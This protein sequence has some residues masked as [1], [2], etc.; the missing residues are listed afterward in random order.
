MVIDVSM[1][2]MANTRFI[3]LVLIFFLSG[4]LDLFAQ[5]TNGTLAVANESGTTIPEINRKIA[6]AKADT[7]KVKLLIKQSHLYWHAKTNKNNFLDSSRIAAGLAQNLSA[8]LHFTQ[9]SNEANFMLCRI[10]VEKGDVNT[11]L[12]IASKVYGEERVRLLLTVGEHFVIVRELHEQSDKAYSVIKEAIKT[13]QVIGSR[14]WYYESLLL[15][16]K[17]YFVKGDVSEGKK[18]ILKIISSCDRVADYAGGAR[19]WSELGLYMPKSAGTYKDV[20]HS[21]AM[22]VKFYLKAGNRREA[23]YSLRDKSMAHLVANEP[24][25]AEQNG[26]EVLL[27][28]KTLNEQPTFQ[29]LRYMSNIYQVK[30]NYPKA[31]NFALAAL[32]R[33]GELSDQR[34]FEAHILLGVIY[35]E[36]DQ[37]KKALPYFK[38]AC[39]YL[40]AVND[41]ELFFW[42]YREIND[43]IKIGDSRNALRQFTAFMSKFKPATSNQK[44]IVA[45]TYGDLYF[46]LNDLRKAEA[47]YL[48]MIAQDKYSFLESRQLLGYDSNIHGSEAFYKIGR[49]YL[50]RKSHT[51]ARFYLEK[52]LEGPNSFG[53]HQRSNIEHS[54][55]KADSALGNFQS[56]IRHFERSIYLKDS[57]FNAIKSRQISELEIQYQTGLRERSFLALKNK[58]ILQNKE[59]EKGYLE[60]NITFAGIVMLFAIAGLAYKGYRNKKRSNLRLIKQQRKIHDQNHELQGLVADK[61]KLI[62][63]KDWLLKEVHHRVK[64]NLQ[65]VMGLLQQQAS[66]MNNEKELKAIRNSEHRMHSIA[67]I[68][69]KLYQSDSYMSV[70]MPDYINELVGYLQECFDG[71]NRIRFEKQIVN[72]DFDVNIAVPIGLILNEAITN[73]IKYACQDH[74]ECKIR[75]GLQ[76]AGEYDYLLEIGDNGAG[77]SADFDLNGSSSMGFNLIRG[78]SRQLG[79]KLELSNKKG[80]AIRTIIHIGQQ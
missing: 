42:K 24:D 33:A 60:R 66:F 31:L 16:G 54:L 1:K 11:A 30:G 4:A 65:I 52:A 22:A 38:V 27:M 2:F 19:Y 74:Q 26:L 76:Q 70:N 20:I 34:K 71:Q 49:F 25:S 3:I 68:H 43:R 6:V 5:R 21:H 35:D 10:A 51:K 8:R 9:G 64:N 12:A 17:Y 46:A 18:A 48:E 53:V 62:T 59:L 29:T 55:F 32:K 75:I 14:P 72:V 15:L 45:A 56:A 73:A 44:E 79:G 23:A 40:I 63:E 7:S 36:L 39:D 13:S 28:L 47:C 77:L 41:Y 57:M 37:P 80:L 69:Q 50:A 61:D 58:N 78:L 67:L